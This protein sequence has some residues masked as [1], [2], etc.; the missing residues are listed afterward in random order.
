MGLS[1]DI[2]VCVSC[3]EEREADRWEDFERRRRPP[4]GMLNEA[5]SH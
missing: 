4:A 2:Y 3:G 5:T 1:P